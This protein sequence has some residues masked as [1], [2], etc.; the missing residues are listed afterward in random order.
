MEIEDLYEKFNK[1]QDERIGDRMMKRD[2]RRKP[3]SSV[4]NSWSEDADLP[5]SEFGN[6]GEDAV[7]TH[8]LSIMA[9]CIVL[10]EREG[11]PAAM[12]FKLAN[13]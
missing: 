5:L 1:L 2:P 7:L 12:L 6:N 9:R 13:G 11:M 8:K 4:I 10:A 3:V